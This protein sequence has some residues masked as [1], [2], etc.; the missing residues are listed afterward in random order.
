MSAALKGAPHFG[1]VSWDSSAEALIAVAARVVILAPQRGPKVAKFLVD[2]R[3]RGD[4]ARHF[5]AQHRPKAAAKAVDER[6]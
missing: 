2:F 3:G 5:F 1:Q 6:F 4:R